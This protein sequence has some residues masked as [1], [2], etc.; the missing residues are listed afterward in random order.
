MDLTGKLLVAM[1]GMGD[2]RF[3]HSVVAICA[4]SPE[5]AMGLI[6]NKPLP[7]PGLGDLLE[8]LGIPVT[9]SDRPEVTPI[10]FGGP[11]ET[12]R[13]FVLHSREWQGRGGAGMP[14]STDMAMTA[15]R[16]VL[17]DIAAGCGPHRRLLA[18]GYA[19][20]G[21][22][23][24]EAEILANGWLIAE[25]NDEIALGGEYGTKWTRAL[26][27]MGIEPRTLSATAGHA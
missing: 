23:Q 25:G 16:D 18:L 19:G 15:T 1:P 12:G 3:D 2:P 11:V 27:T 14:I 20:W 13:G 21:P 24:L 26:A 10:L 6:V 9:A 17:E 7:E 5:G 8:Q 22:G 4:H